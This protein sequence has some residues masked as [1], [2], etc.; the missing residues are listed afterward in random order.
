M[1]LLQYDSTKYESQRVFLGHDIWACGCWTRI[2]ISCQVCFYFIINYILFT[3]HTG[4]SITYTKVYNSV[5]GKQIEAMWA[6]RNKPEQ[7]YTE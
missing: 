1:N 6:T 7:K 3:D 2:L 5:K 4:Q